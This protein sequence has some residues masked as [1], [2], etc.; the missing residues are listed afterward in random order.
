MNISLPRSCATHTK[1]LTLRYSRSSRARGAWA[2][3]PAP[4]RAS[5][6]GHLRAGALG[7]SSAPTV[8]GPAARTPWGLLAVW[9][10]WP[11]FLLGAPAVSTPEL[12][13]PRP[14]AQVLARGPLSLPRAAHSEFSS[15]LGWV[16]SRCAQKHTMPCS[17]SPWPQGWGE[18][19]ATC[20]RR[21]GWSVAG[22][23][24]RPLSRWTPPVGSLTSLGLS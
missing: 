16:C 8:M 19:L 14:V 12:P 2:P 18:R 10:R 15:G 6:G 5:P 17:G 7:G 20:R 21:P 9:V 1:R 13:S 24:P 22:T 23:E 4:A 11:H 3:G